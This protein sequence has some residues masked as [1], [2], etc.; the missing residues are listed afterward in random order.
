MQ[1]LTLDSFKYFMKDGTICKVLF[2]DHYRALSLFQKLSQRW[3]K[4]A[5]TQAAHMRGAES[6]MKQV[7]VL[8]H[9]PPPL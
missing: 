9:P 6:G 1:V 3:T 4:V 5:K 2:K 7:A 8:L